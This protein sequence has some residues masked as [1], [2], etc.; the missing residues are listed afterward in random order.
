MTMRSAPCTIFAMLVACGTTSSGDGTTD[1]TTGSG[2]DADT[3]SSTAPPTTSSTSANTTTDA[4]TTNDPTTTTDPTTSDVTGDTTDAET[5]SGVSDECITVTDA[6]HHQFECDDLVFD[7]NVPAACVDGPCGMIVD[8]HGLT[9]SAQMEDANTNLAALGERHGYIVVQPNA[10]PAPP[11]SNWMP[12]VDDDKVF[13]FMQRVAT[14]WP[15]DPDRWH[16]TGFSQGGFMS[17]RFACD[18]SDVLASVAPAA[19]CGA[20]F[21]DCTFADGDAPAEP[22]DILFLH[23][24]DDALVSY[25]CVQPRLDAVV[26]HF[27]LGE[28]PTIEYEDGYRRVRYEGDEMV[29]EHLAHDLSAQSV[30]IRGHCYPGSDDPGDAPGQ[31]FS[32]ACVEPTDLHWGEA[33]IAFFQAHP[34]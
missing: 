31:L 14:V 13:A 27:G 1:D 7:V 20:G 24:T 15:V 34:R 6:G 4:T 9:M 22:L 11:G 3:G 23:G 18:H 12:A 17:W 26:A 21:D 33:V 28:E 8:V 5:T 10:N 19:A 29:L 2:T 25:D 16:F 32:F 30:V